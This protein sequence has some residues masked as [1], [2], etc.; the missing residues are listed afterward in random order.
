M[1]ARVFVIILL[2]SAVGSASASHERPSGRFLS[3][4]GSSVEDLVDAA[5][6]REPGM[7]AL[8]RQVDAARGRARQAAL[9]PNPTLTLSRNEEIGGTDNNTLVGFAWPLDLSRKSARVATAERETE[10]ARAEILD[11]ERL[12]A[13]D[14]RRGAGEV[15]AA[16]RSLRV[17]EDLLEASRR[18]AELVDARVREGAAPALERGLLGVEISRIE[19]D[20]VLGEARAERALLE[21]KR[22]SGLMPDAELTLREDLERLI[23][24]GGAER[25]S[26]AHEARPDVRAADARVASA[27]A[28]RDLAG[29]SGR[30]DASLIAAYSRM[31]AGFPQSGFGPVGGIERVRAVFHRVDFG[32]SWELP[33]R[34]RNQGEVQAM[35][36]ER[37]AAQ[38]EAVRARLVA[39]TDLASAEVR[40]EKGIEALS[41][42]RRGV[43]DQA[44]ENLN[45]LRESYVLGRSALLDVIAE[46]RRYLEAERGYTEVLLEVYQARVDLKSA[47]GEAR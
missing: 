9:R 21:V 10:V 32:V 40:E 47:R 28:R 20:L 33:I 7:Q 6:A 34:N 2:G 13:A 23:G 18:F 39:A 24:P 17:A 15:L 36:A 19:T 30:S 1:N 3:S 27:E 37:T 42:Y 4:S 11:L 25:S 43:L 14:V 41:L 29:T 26:T 45:V 22:L 38:Q 5:L 12:L 31:D 35:D 44:R 46:E 8:R 16:V